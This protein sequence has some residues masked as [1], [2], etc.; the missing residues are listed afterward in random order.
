MSVEE[1]SCLSEDFASRTTTSVLILYAD[2]YFGRRMFQQFYGRKSKT[3]TCYRINACMWSESSVE[4]FIDYCDTLPF[5][6]GHSFRS[7]Q[8]LPTV[9]DLG[10]QAEKANLGSTIDGGATQGPDNADG[11]SHQLN[12]F[13]RR[14]GPKLHQAVLASDLIVVELRSAQ[15]VFDIVHL[16]TTKILRKTKRLILVSSLLTWYATPPLQRESVEE[17]NGET[18]SVENEEEGEHH[19]EE[20]EEVQ[21]PMKPD[22]VEA[23][24][25]PLEV[26]EDDYEN[27]PLEGEA[28]GEL[29]LLTEDQYNRRIPHAKYFN[30][31][32][33]ERVVASANS[34]DRHLQTCVVFAGLTY[35]EGED[36]MESFFRQVWS[37]EEHGLPIYGSGSQIV[38]CVH[39]R[40]LVTFAQRLLEAAAPPTSRYVFATDNSNVSWRR[41]VL[42]LNR[43][44]GGEKTFH[45]PPSEYLLHKNVELFTMNLRVEN[46]TMNEMMDESD[47][48]ARG[49]FVDSID[50]VAH[51]FIESHNLQPIR[52]LI[53]GPPLSGKTAL[54]GAVAKR[55]Y[56]VPTFTIEQ[57]REEYKEH[58]EILKS[59]LAKFRQ[60][61]HEREKTRR[62]EAKKRAFLRPRNKPEVKEEEEDDQNAMGET[63]QQPTASPDSGRQGNMESTRLVDCSTTVA[64]DD[65]DG[66][67]VDFSL[68]EEEMQNVEAL[69]DDWYQ[70]N[71]RAI[72]I[73]D[74]IASMERV[75]S[76]RIRVQPPSSNDPLGSSN[77]KKRKEGTK[78]KRV[79]K[80]VNKKPV[81]E[82]E[83][84]NPVQQE[85]APFQDKAL[86]CMVR[87]RLSRPDCRNQGYV[88]D[89]FPE[90]VEQARLVFGQT[91]LE[92]PENNEDTVISLPSAP[93][94]SGGYARTAVVRHSASLSANA[95]PESTEL[96]DEDRLP[97]FVFVL[98][99]PDNYLLDRLT[100]VSKISGETG[101]T[102]EKCLRRFEAAMANYQQQYT[103]AEYTLPNFFETAST[104]AK[105]LTPGGRTPTVLAVD[106]S[107]QPLLPPP[108]PESDFAVPEPGQ[109]EKLLCAYVGPSH[110]LGLSPK[111]LFDEEIRARN[112][113]MEERKKEMR[114]ITE[115]YEREL[116]ECMMESEQRSVV[117]D[118][119]RAIDLADREALEERKRPLRMYLNHNIIPLLSKGLVEVCKRRP[120]DPVD[121][122]AEW[123]MLHNPHDDSCF[124]L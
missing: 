56:H 40:D 120:V 117:E 78:Q 87:W 5:Q 123:L 43:A 77:P 66:K 94:G 28:E 106:V 85:S 108:P 81:A 63:Q 44:F 95:P 22:E 10:T 38:P 39:I 31:R 97:D 24:L 21:Q 32:E 114:A 65:V 7:R 52:I 72:Q 3:G 98:T 34:D 61:L 76:M 79:A 121:F 59:R 82:E 23:L 88:L 46:S 48:A 12:V 111:Q 99:A 29:E 67:A 30:W 119:R 57:V 113:E 42:A 47:W 13:W 112:L 105:V 16:L 122:L 103:N 49:G 68:N 6:M 92:L 20:Q 50:K 84:H 83:E 2:T 8:S 37:R 26:A 58:I 116:R 35:G 110:T 90:T 60:C 19:E 18:D 55:H 15:D 4:N 9:I 17:V 118:A 36:V 101:S 64:E 1:V 80:V 27:S 75:L 74:T 70:G 100:A 33:A 53:L 62:E 73:R 41:M 45:V 96:C 69:V 109:L 51:E 104:V 124:E 93:A 91:P 71:E 11:T 102:E 25:G 54:S 14:N 89:G 86:A 107:G 115:Q